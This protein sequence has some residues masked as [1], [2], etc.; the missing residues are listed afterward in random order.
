MKKSYIKIAASFLVLSLIV[1]ASSC[2]K[3]NDVTVDPNVGFTDDSELFKFPPV[4][5]SEV[6]CA[7]P[8]LT[9]AT[10]PADE[11]FT[12][13]TDCLNDLYDPNPEEEYSDAVEAMS[14]LVFHAI[15]ELEITDEMLKEIE[16]A[17]ET[18]T[19]IST[20]SFASGSA[21]IAQSKFIKCLIE[22]VGIADIKKLLE[23]YRAGRLTKKKLW[24]IVK[25]NLK[26]KLGPIGAAISICEFLL[27]IGK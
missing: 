7:F 6:G 20:I 4:E 25:R 17:I 10:C 3:N 24:K 16:L 14:S 27:C 9:D 5:G 11:L 1:F 26:R 12:P 8:D 22:V 19:D 15:T 21:S 23:A 2:T 13:Y 18:G